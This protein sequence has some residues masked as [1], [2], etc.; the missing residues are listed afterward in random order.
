MKVLFLFGLTVAWLP[1]HSFSVGCR[2]LHRLSGLKQPNIPLQFCSVPAG[3][4]GVESRY[5]QGHVPSGGS[6][7]EWSLRLPASG[8]C[9]GPGRFLLFFSPLLLTGP[10]W[11]QRLRRVFPQDE[12]ISNLL[13]PV[14]PHIA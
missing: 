11:S 4:T 1:A 2:H 6:R 10:L 5:G 13:S 14:F 7:E 12:L 9:P 3:L 8:H